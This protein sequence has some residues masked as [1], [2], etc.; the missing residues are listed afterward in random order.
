MPRR[1]SRT[2]PYFDPSRIG[3]WR[4]PDFKI[5]EPGLCVKACRT[6]YLQEVVAILRC[7]DF[8]HSLTC[9]S[10]LFSDVLWV[11]VVCAEVAISTG[12]HLEVPI[13]TW[14]SRVDEDATS[15]WQVEDALG[16]Q[17]AD[18]HM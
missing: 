8:Q 4:S 12:C 13:V 11:D 14:R 2:Q 16:A 1:S 6:S 3:D 10:G 18:R 15:E 7:R 17:T 5:G 9:I